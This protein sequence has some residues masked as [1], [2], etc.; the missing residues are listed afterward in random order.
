VLVHPNFGYSFLDL[1]ANVAIS[2]CLAFL[3]FT[4]GDGGD[5]SRWESSTE[6]DSWLGARRETSVESMSI[7]AKKRPITGKQ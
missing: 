7:Y 1:R 5:S 6:R 4:F 2:L 3:D